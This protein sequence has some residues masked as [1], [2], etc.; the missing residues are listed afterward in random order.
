[1]EPTVRLLVPVERK[2]YNIRAPKHISCPIY[3][4]PGIKTKSIA[5]SFTAKHSQ[6]VKKAMRD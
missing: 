1:M 3:R 2:N 6:K 4:R 5:S